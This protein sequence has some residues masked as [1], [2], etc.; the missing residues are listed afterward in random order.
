LASRPVSPTRTCV[1]CGVRAARSEFIRVV[2]AGG[3][4][5][6]DVAA[7]LPGRGAYLHPSLEC[8]ERARRRRAFSRA[9]R[10]PAALPDSRLAEYLAGN[11]HRRAVQTTGSAGTK[12]G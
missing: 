7:R 2:A 10:L 4:I 8:L 6:P 12:E 11:G 3:E 9:L 1:G 5:V